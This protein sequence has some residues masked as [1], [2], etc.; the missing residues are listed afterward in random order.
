MTKKDTQQERLIEA[1]E[2][3]AATQKEL[4]QAIKD[5]H[6]CLEMLAGIIAKAK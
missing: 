1:A 4:V 2:Q 6:T 3:I 5:L